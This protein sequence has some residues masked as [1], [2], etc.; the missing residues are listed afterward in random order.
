MLAN[1]IGTV[2]LVLAKR[3][4]LLQIVMARMSLNLLINGAVGAIPIVGISSPSG[5]G[6]TREMQS[7]C[8]VLRLNRTGKRSRPDFMWPASSVGPSCFCSLPLQRSC[9]SS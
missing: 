6:V 4:Q 2:I 7:C 3:L 5:F 9:G 8:G 1:L